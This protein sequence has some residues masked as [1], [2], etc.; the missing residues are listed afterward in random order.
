MKKKNN[1]K[2]PAFPFTNAISFIPS[3]IQDLSQ[4]KFFVKIYMSTVYTVPLTY[5]LAK[6]RG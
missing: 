4:I 2:I 6:N 5:L 3:E 1:H